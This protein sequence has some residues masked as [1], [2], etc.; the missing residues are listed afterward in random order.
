[1]TSHL[2]DPERVRQQYATEA[3]LRARQAM[4][5]EMRGPNARQA[6]WEAIAASE[7]KR[8]LEVGG[9]DG[10]L[11]QRMQDELG[12]DVS[13]VDLS[14]RMV[15]LARERGVHAEVGSVEQL[16][17]ADGA[18]DT[19][20]AAWMLY[21]VSDL[22][23]G[24]AEIARVLRPGGRLVANTT[25]R[26]HLAEFFALI[27]YGEESRKSDFAAENGE[28][29]LCRHFR[30]VERTELVASATVRDRQ[31]LVDYRASIPVRTL[32]VP[33]DVALP[34]EVHSRGALFVATK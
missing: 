4:W 31:T 3:N 19:V 6:L 28:A 9:G 1:M 16:R 25:S 30:K 32:P 21:H 26:R 23:R 5:R 11:S 20:V 10:W 15:E 2:N 8:V 29:A 17:F 27:S 14:A 12:C 33:E 34:F 24:L 13:M 7:P 22:E 18:F